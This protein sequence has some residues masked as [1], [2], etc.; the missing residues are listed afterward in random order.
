MGPG[1]SRLFWDTCLQYLFTDWKYTILYYIKNEKCLKNED[2]LKCA[3]VKHLK[4]KI[5]TNIKTL[6][7]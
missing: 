4:T 3:N 1:D 7:R 5:A 2:D 6:K